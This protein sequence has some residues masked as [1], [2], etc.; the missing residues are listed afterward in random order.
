MERKHISDKKKT[1]ACSIL[2]MA[3]A[4]LSVIIPLTLLNNVYAV[5]FLYYIGMCLLVPFADMLLI[6]RLTFTEALRFLGFRSENRNSS[7]TV[8]LIHGSIILVLM[9]GGFFAFRKVFISS[10]IVSSL[11][12]WGVSESTKWV[13]FFFMVLFNG[14]VEEIFW[15]GYTYGR[16]KDVL[17]KWPA[18]LIVTFFYTSYH[19]ATVLTFF[20]VSFMGIQTVIFIFL[21]GLLWGWMRYRFRDILASAIGHT[22]LTVGYMTIFMLV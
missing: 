20:K 9:L 3:L 22:L 21:A 8:G 1:V 14:I 10:D 16:L 6:R 18:I 13:L 19:L 12:Q 15:R 4:S 2:I 17:K 7:M 11:A 5:F